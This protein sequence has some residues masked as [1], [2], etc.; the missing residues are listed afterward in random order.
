MTCHILSV[1]FSV[2]MKTYLEMNECYSLVFDELSFWNLLVISYDYLFIPTTTFLRD[3]SYISAAIIC[4]YSS[5]LPYATLRI[6]PQNF[7]PT[8]QLVKRDSMH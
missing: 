4:L 3:I 8:Q 6:S 7:H 1:I 5:S 2:L